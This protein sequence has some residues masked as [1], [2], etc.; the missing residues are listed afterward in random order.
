M[1]KHKCVGQMMTQEEGATAYE[2][3]RNRWLTRIK[4]IEQI[5]VELEEDPLLSISITEKLMHKR[6]MMARELQ[7]YLIALFTFLGGGQRL[8]VY[9]E[10]LN[11]DLFRDEDDQLV[12][13][14]ESEKV[15]RQNI[16]RMPVPPQL[17]KFMEYFQQKIRP[18]LK[19]GPYGFL[20]SKCLC[21]WVNSVQ[22]NAFACLCAT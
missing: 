6:W 8:Q 2:W 1:Y 15:P 7:R 10:L 5:E 19:K 13:K 21:F 18:I 9:A 14:L 17:W 11:D 12:F 16:N 22:N 4:Y 3:L 20:D